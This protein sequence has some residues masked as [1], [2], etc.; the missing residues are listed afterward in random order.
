MANHYEVTLALW[1]KDGSDLTP[2]D[3]AD[4]VM[5]MADAIR[6]DG[7]VTAGGGHECD[8]LVI[9]HPSTNPADTNEAPR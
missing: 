6:G 4:A 2:S 8:G 9:P 7:I 5:K 3:V 1:R